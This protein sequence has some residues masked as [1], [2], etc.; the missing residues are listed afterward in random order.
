MCGAAPANIPHKPMHHAVA[1]FDGV[2]LMIADLVMRRPRASINTAG[3]RPVCDLISV[4]IWNGALDLL[5]IERVA[6][7]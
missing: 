5:S 7:Q 3:D 4:G 1:D 6:P 2:V